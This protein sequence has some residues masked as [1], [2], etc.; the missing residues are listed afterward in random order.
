MVLAKK[1]LKEKN[2][3]LEGKLEVEEKL[4]I[5]KGKFEA[6]E[7]EVK[8]VQREKDRL[9]QEVEERQEQRGTL[10]QVQFQNI[11]G[12]VFRDYS[13][14]DRPELKLKLDLLDDKTQELVDAIG[15]N[16][17]SEVDQLSL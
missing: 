11:Y 7:E 14:F 13:V 17:I 12:A 6:V 16:R 2:D 9:R 15:N 8:V 3:A 10:T 1:N 5:L 4:K